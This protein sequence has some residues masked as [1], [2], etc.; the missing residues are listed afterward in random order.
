[1]DFNLVV[2]GKQLVGIQK[3]K[4]Q[5]SKPKV[6]RWWM[7]LICQD[8]IIILWVLLLQWQKEGSEAYFS[9]AMGII[10]KMNLLVHEVLASATWPHLIAVRTN[11]PCLWREHSNFESSL[12]ICHWSVNEEDLSVSALK[13]QGKKIT[14]WHSKA[15]EKQ[16]AYIIFVYCH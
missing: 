13:W 10:M 3:S 15:T 14:G 4:T 16:L 1:M 9:L 12:T 7:G 5:L 11:L 2:T 8:L 6:S